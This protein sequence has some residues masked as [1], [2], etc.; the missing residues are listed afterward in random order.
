MHLNFLGTPKPNPA[1]V[2]PIANAVKKLG[3]DP[4]I[5]ELNLR[6][7]KGQEEIE[8]V[9]Q[10]LQSS[11]SNNEKDKGQLLQNAIAMKQQ[12]IQTL[13]LQI[14]NIREQ[15]SQSVENEHSKFDSFV[16]SLK[17]GD[18]PVDGIYHLQREGNNLSIIFNQ[19]NFEK[20]LSQNNNVTSVSNITNFPRNHYSA[21]A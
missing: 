19:P 7:E 14:E 15:K 8:E 6:I 17:N 12:N 9:A 21:I 1:L 20:T 16:S 18:N 4:E 13:R 5:N 2:Q 3:D 10:E 11:I